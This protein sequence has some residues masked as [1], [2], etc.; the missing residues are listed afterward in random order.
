MSQHHVSRREFVTGLGLGIAGLSIGDQ[1]RA[2][3]FLRR[4]CGRRIRTT[5]GSRFRDFRPV[6]IGP[7]GIGDTTHYGFVVDHPAYWGIPI[8]GFDPTP[9]PADHDHTGFGRRPECLRVTN[10]C[11]NTCS[12]WGGQEFKILATRTPPLFHAF[13]HKT[14]RL[15]GQPRP[16]K[17]ERR[18][19]DDQP[20]KGNGQRACVELFRAEYKHNEWVPDVTPT[21]E[22]ERFDT[23]QLITDAN[24]EG[25]FIVTGDPAWVVEKVGP[26]GALWLVILQKDKNNTPIC[27]PKLGDGYRLW[28]H[29]N[30]AGETAGY[31]WTICEAHRFHRL[32]IQIELSGRLNDPPESS[33]ES[34]SVCFDLTWT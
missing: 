8:P 13:H 10:V 32:Q 30:H 20:R 11:I 5:S 22:F 33:E 27:K 6:R 7:G 1:A 31:D 19:E 3:G 17:F 28:H 18:G 34:I 23:R 15:P 25:Y 24:R 29:L 16:F 14:T 9:H 4:Q 2:A 12:G 26:L 21:V